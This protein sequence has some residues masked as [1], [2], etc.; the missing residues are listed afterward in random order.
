MTGQAKA[1]VAGGV[2]EFVGLGLVSLDIWLEP[3]RESFARSRRRTRD[4][5]WRA[6]LW[7]ERTI[8]RRPRLHTVTASATMPYETVGAISPV[9]S[10]PKDAP[11]EEQLRLLAGLAVE[12]QERLNRLDQQIV[13]LTASLAQNVEGL[14]DEAREMIDKAIRE[15][16][17]AYRGWRVV[18]FALVV[19][20]STIVLAASAS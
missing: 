20:G 1:L 4:L 11:P 18:G 19:V 10:I 6:W 9:K 3:A 13:S 2:I 12:A 14:R 8:L 7:F 16:E 5:A 17:R 15:S